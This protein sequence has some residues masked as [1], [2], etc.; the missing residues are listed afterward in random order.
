MQRLGVDL[1]NDEEIGDLV[2]LATTI[3]DF[4]GDL[5]FIVELV[6]FLESWKECFFEEFHN[7][8]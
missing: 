5:E 7:I 8:E 2:E 3:V 4:G 1:G 6:S